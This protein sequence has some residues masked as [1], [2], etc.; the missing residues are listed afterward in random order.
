MNRSPAFDRYAL[1]AV[2]PT[3][4]IGLAG[5]DLKRPGVGIRCW[6]PPMS[7]LS[8]FSRYQRPAHDNA[9]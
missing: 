7:I 4:E 2:I 5:S 3:N 9:R 1:T 8:V 6:F